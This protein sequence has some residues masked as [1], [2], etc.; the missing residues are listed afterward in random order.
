MVAAVLAAGAVQAVGGTEM[1]D[2]KRVDAPAFEEDFTAVVHAGDRFVAVGRAGQVAVSADG[3]HWTAGEMPFPAD[4]VEVFWSGERI[5]ALSSLGDAFGSRDG[6]VWHHLSFRRIFP[7]RA[8]WAGDEAVVVAIGRL[9]TLGL[10]TTANGVD[11]GFSSP[12]AY[13][14][15]PADIVWTG[16]RLAGVGQN[17]YGGPDEIFAAVRLADKTWKTA[18][19]GLFGRVAA[20]G[21]NGAELL[22]IVETQNGLRAARSPDGLDWIEAPVDAMLAGLPSQWSARLHGIAGRWAFPATAGGQ[23]V[24]WHSSGGSH[25]ERQTLPGGSANAL[26]QSPDGAVVVGNDGALFFGGYPMKPNNAFGYPLL[27]SGPA[28]SLLIEPLLDSYEPGTVVDITIVS[29][30]GYE[31]E[32]WVGDVSGTDKTVSIV[33]D[34]PKAVAAR[35]RL[36]GSTEG[37]IRWLYSHGKDGENGVAPLDDYN[38]DGVA[39]L[40]NYISGGSIGSGGFSRPGSIAATANPGPRYEATLLAD[41][42]MRYW[43]EYSDDL[44]NWTPANLRYDGGEQ[45]WVIRDPAGR[46]SAEIEASVEEPWEYLRIAISGGEDDPPRFFRTRVEVP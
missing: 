46:V 30:S 9:G 7:V 4:L 39:N 22:A 44:R 38:R 23:A 42:S 10:V 15:S 29:P 1:P 25:W 19:L 41:R 18:E 11:W 21:W 33:M 24:V 3:S 40:M 6:L 43:I 37:Y 12:G 2:W 27:A 36:T 20:F 16:E 31:F 13:P 5:F 35:F 45:A 8:E 14:R 17:E 32:R 28:Q 34:S 26:A